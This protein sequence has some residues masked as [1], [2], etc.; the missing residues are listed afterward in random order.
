MS[1]HDNLFDD[2]DAFLDDIDSDED[3]FGDADPLDNRTPVRTIAEFDEEVERRIKFLLNSKNTSQERE[4]VA[5]WLGESGAPK[6]ITA[7][8][9]VYEKDKKNPNVQQAAAYALGQFKALDEA[10][11]RD[12]GESVSDALERPENQPIIERLQNIALYD[13]RGKRPRFSRQTMTRI[14]GGLAASLV[15]LLVIY[16]LIPTTEAEDPSA[17]IALRPTEGTLGQRSV[18]ELQL[19]TNELQQDLQALQTQ[20]NGSLNCD[21]PLI[22]PAA[23]ELNTAVTND[24]PT[25]I[26]LVDQYN[27]AHQNYTFAVTIHDLAC[28][29]TPPTLTD[30]DRA[31]GNLAI[32]RALTEIQTVQADLPEEVR[33]ADASARALAQATEMIQLTRDTIAEQTA[34]PAT[35][36]PTF[37]PTPGISPEQM[38]RYVGELNELIDRA[39]SPQGFNSTL[40]LYWEQARDNANVLNCR[41]T[42][43]RIPEDY[44][45]SVED[46]A[47]NADLASAVSLVNTGLQL[48]RD[49]WGFFSTSCQNATVL[50]NFSTGLL[51]TT[52][53]NTSFD[54]A[55]TILDRIRGMRQAAPT[56]TP[57]ATP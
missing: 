11:V 23:F 49:A 26:P 57:T 28:S 41:A 1:D 55:R 24:L 32:S 17:R 39:T 22:E 13:Q 29:N 42:Q 16:L 37:T 45:L 31:S 19:R 50:T 3:P 2:D 47:L 34:N 4:Q 48:S 33:I 25:L 53:A 38:I 8:K 52:T 18:G 54:E 35:F 10:I 40:Q 44:V 6:A 7:L 56:P 12:P 51:Q 27:L 15:V 43:P 46:A 21:A 30:E 9:K 14:L 36:T 20:F 5:Y